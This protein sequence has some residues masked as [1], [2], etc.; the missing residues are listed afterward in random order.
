VKKF[1]NWRVGIG[2]LLIGLSIALYFLHFSIFRDSKHIFIYLL[3]DIAFLPV[4][5]LIVTLIIHH[6]LEARSR[7]S[8]MKKLN[9]LIGAFFSEVGT[10]LLSMLRVFDADAAELSSAMKVSSEWD[11]KKFSEVARSLGGHKYNIGIKTGDLGALSAFLTEKTGFLLSL[12]ANPS[13]LEHES[14]TESL[15]AVFHFAEELASRNDLLTLP[16]TDYEHLAGDMKRIYSLVSKQWLLY[17]MHLKA[18]YPY[19]FSLAMRKNPFV[20]DS[21]VIVY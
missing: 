7:R 18:D 16:G 9:M 17:M 12:L 1:F 13:L 4:D 3:G 19:L 11:D 6:I 21:S 10:E 14:F 5:V 20:K 15:W 8:R 2:L